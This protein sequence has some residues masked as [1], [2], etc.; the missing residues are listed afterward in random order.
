MLS[1]E[2]ELAV[3]IR[4]INGVHVNHHNIPEAREGEILEELTAK[5]SSPNDQDLALLQQELLD[6]RKPNIRIKSILNSRKVSKRMV[7]EAWE[8]REEKRREEKRREEKRVE[9]RKRVEKP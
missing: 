1:P 2:E 3:E 6:L 4:E 7:Q 8:R 9:K 5:T